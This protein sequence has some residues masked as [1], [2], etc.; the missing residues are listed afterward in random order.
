M[1]IMDS[2]VS[3]VKNKLEVIRLEKRYA[4]R[5]NRAAYKGGMEYRDGE[6]V[7]AQGKEKEKG[8]NVGIRELGVGSEKRR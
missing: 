7:R 2:L 3:R 1:E 4:K 8:A 6:Y 5:T